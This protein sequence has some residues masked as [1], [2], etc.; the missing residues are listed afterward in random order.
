M[1]GFF[2]VFPGAAGLFGPCHNFINAFRIIC[3][4]E[5]YEFLPRETDAVILS[6]IGKARL[7]AGTDHLQRWSSPFQEDGCQ[8][9]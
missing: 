1:L 5:Y 9:F 2:R 8:L 3:L 7:E 6:C 4:D